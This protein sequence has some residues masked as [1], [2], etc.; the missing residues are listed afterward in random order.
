MSV[1]GSSS[2]DISGELRETG[3]C[4]Y[5]SGQSR[6]ALNSYTND[7]ISRSRLLMFLAEK[8]G[9]RDPMLSLSLQGSC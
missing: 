5:T 3:E 4:I 6:T 7:N 8:H 2:G 9:T 1:L